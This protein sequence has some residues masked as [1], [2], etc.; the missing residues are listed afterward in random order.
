MFSYQ[1]S[2][3]ARKF[4]NDKKTPIPVDFHINT[5]F[6]IWWWKSLIIFLATVDCLLCDDI[7]SDKVK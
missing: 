4:P 1:N 5:N 2:L 6:S 3:K 7:G